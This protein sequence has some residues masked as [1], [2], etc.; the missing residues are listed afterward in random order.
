MQV[1]KARDT[2]R[3]LTWKLELEIL[4]MEE[5]CGTVSAIICIKEASTLVLIIILG[6]TLEDHWHG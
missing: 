1:Q 5:Q 2:I 6:F 4:L 3:I